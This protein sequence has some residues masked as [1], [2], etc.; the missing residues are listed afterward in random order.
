MTNRILIIGY[1]GLGN[2]ILKTP[3][4]KK[5]KTIGPK[6]VVDVLI[7]EKYGVAEI[8]NEIDGIDNII[9]LPERSSLLHQIACFLKL[10]KN[11]YDGVLVGF[12]VMRAFVALGLVLLDAKKT[13]VHYRIMG[14]FAYRVKM[15]IL[16]MMVPNLAFQIVGRER[17]ES[18][19]NLELLKAFGPP[20][21]PIETQAKLPARSPPDD[22]REK[23]GL[24]SSRI[25]LVQPGAA[26]GSLSA[27][28]W[29]SENFFD[30]VDALYAEFSDIQVVLAGD[31]GDQ[32]SLQDSALLKRGDVINLLGKTDLQQLLDLVSLAEIVI[33]HDSG[34]MHIADALDKKMVALYGPTDYARTKPLGESVK[35]VFSKNECFG[36][37]NYFATDEISL[38]K[39]YPDSFCMSGIS[40][41]DVMT[42]VKALL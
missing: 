42:E 38:A 25:V 27:K 28:T 9:S 13:I 34:I 10:R 5:I 39:K 22:F 23:L 17:H 4:I 30:L 19:L 15:K 6:N 35:F 26:N 37:M 18:V 31:H 12:D 11:R 1:T 32:V 40:V 24:L 7:G 8:A 20:F 14:S 36:A 16:E 3:M 33:A 29:A 2:F 41:E 21:E